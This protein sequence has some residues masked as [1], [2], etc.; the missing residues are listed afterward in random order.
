[1]FFEFVRPFR[2]LQSVSAF[3]LLALPVTAFASS[4]FEQLYLEA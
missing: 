3:L 4:E 2:S 1:M